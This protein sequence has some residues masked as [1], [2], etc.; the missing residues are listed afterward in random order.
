M[1]Q[2]TLVIGAH[3]ESDQLAEEDRGRDGE[4]KLERE[5]FDQTS[6]VHHHRLKPDHQRI[7]AS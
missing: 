5:P 1:S 6:H 2:S 7:S 4:D 3:A